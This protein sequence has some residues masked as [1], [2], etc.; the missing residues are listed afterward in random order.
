MRSWRNRSDLLRGKQPVFTW[1]AAQ[2]EAYEYV[3]DAL[4]AGIHL[5]APDFDLP[6]H[7]QTDASENG[8][9]SVLYQL[10][11]C[12]IEDQYPYCKD[13]HSPDN[14]DIV[15]FFSIAWTEAQRLRPPFYLE[16][17]SLL[18]STNEVKFYALS[19][20]FPLYTYSDHMP[21]AWMKS[22]RKDRSRSSSSNS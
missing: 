14:M 7:L 5:A 2:Q 11:K 20:K 3:R 8:K 18:W 4:L 21:L 16:A 19:S 13:K 10:S 9:G 6:F 17:D 1:G 12:P 15:A 22:L